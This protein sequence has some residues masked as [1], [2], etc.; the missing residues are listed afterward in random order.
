M[1]FD[2][3]VYITWSV[4]LQS[5]DPWSA[6]YTCSIHQYTHTYT[7]YLNT[8]THTPGGDVL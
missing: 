1:S 8:Q 7:L 4:D 6:K 3:L 5:I 2:L